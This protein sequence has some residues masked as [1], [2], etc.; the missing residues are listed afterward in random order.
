[1]VDFNPMF[2]MDRDYMWRWYIV[3]ARGKLVCMSTTVFSFYEEAR[4]DLESAFPSMTRD[5]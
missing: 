4:Q 2:H 5:S 3:G 1:M